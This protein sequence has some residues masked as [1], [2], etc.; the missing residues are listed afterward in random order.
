LT[1]AQQEGD[2]RLAADGD[3]VA[4]LLTHLGAAGHGFVF[5]N[6]SGA[7][8]AMK[9]LLDHPNTAVKAIAHEP[10]VVKVLPDAD[11]W[12]DFFYRDYDEFAQSGMPA[13]MKMFV[14]HIVSPVDAEMISMG[15]DPSPVRKTN[16]QYWVEHELRQYP[17]YD[18]DL[19]AIGAQQGTL[20]LAVGEGSLADHQWTS[21]S[22]LILAQRC[23][24][25]L[26]Q[27]PG[28]HLGFLQRPA[29]FAD[30]ISRALL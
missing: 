17:N 10:P 24:L 21:R 25:P 16:A 9:F 5:G 20:M 18:W 22:S 7:L 4:S 6:S 8:V 13:G 12:R 30:R 29:E 19:E 1:D 14:E 23:G 28:Y 26:L 3:D 15:D 2:A 11:R 27:V